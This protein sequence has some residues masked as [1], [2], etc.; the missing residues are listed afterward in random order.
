[1]KHPLDVI[2]V[3]RSVPEWP[4]EVSSWGRIRRV[5]SAR[6]TKAG[7]IL[8]LQIDRKGYKKVDLTKNGV[9]SSF[10]VHVLVCTVFYGPKPTPRHEVAHWDG[11]PAN[12]RAT[13]LRWATRRENQDDMRR[14][15]TMR[16]SSGL[17]HFRSKFSSDILDQIRSAIGTNVVI[18]VR[19]N[20][21]PSTVWRLR[22]RQ[23]YVGEGSNGT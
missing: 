5:L 17:S 14:H 19:F 21:S 23:S 15:G 9:S 11:I 3:W 2:E 20:T 8:K 16:R 10:K 22:A 13:N 4:Y 18:A 7:Y 6:G 12:C 1:M